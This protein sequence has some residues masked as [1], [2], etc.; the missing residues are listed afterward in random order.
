MGEKSEMSAISS[1]RR[2]QRSR[3]AQN[4]PEPRNRGWYEDT[5]EQLP[6]GPLDSP[7]GP[8]RLFL[9][10]PPPLLL[11]FPSK[12]ARLS[13]MGLAVGEEEGMT[14]LLRRG[15]KGSLF[16][17]SSRGSSCPHSPEG[18]P[19]DADL[20]KDVL[21]EGRGALL[22]H[23][24]DAQPG[25]QVLQEAFEESHEVLC[26][27]DIARHGLCVRGGPVRAVAQRQVSGLPLPPPPDP[28]VH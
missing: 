23:V 12:G 28:Q 6:R 27:P 20:L 1:V 14:H 7:L 5:L 22:D 21:Q 13:N 26:C 15:G 11:S 8:A 4:L 25:L 19:L 10:C 2:R 16:W 18:L 24:M 9:T 17:K 3:S